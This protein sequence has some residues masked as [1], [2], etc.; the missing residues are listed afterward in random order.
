MKDDPDFMKRITLAI[1]TR[2]AACEILE[3]SEQAD[4][5]ELKK[6]YRRAA[7]K[8]HPDHCG[9]SPDANKQFAIVSCAYELL[10]LG[11]P[12]PKILES[13]N[14][15]SGSPEDEKYHLENPWGYFLWWQD[16]FYADS[17]NTKKNKGRVNSC[18]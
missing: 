11:K 6:A 2:K 15:C 7:K 14:A 5:Y 3:V 12:C 13:I 9:N 8:Y 18:I 1:A 17:T 16:K 10:A 4:P